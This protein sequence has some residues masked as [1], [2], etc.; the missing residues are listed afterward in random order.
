[1]SSINGVIPVRALSGVM[2]GKN[3]KA[4]LGMEIGTNLNG[5]AVYTNAWPFQNIAK[6]SEAWREHSGT[7]SYTINFNEDITSL[8]GDRVLS[9]YVAVDV[10]DSNL[11]MAGTWTV[12]WDGTA[13]VSVGNGAPP[14]FTGW[15]SGGSGTWS[16]TQ[17]LGIIVF[18]RNGTLSNLRV[19]PPGYDANNIFR[20]EWLEFQRSC[21]WRSIRTMD[22]SNINGSMVRNWADRTQVAANSYGNNKQYNTGLHSYDGAWA[23]TVPYEHQIALAN[24]LNCDLHVNIPT[25]ATDDFCQQL[26]ALIFANLNPNLKV[27]VEYSNETWNWIFYKATLWTNYLQATKR[28]ATGTTGDNT[29]TT[30]SHGLSENQQIVLVQHEKADLD[31][32]GSEELIFGPQTVRAINVTT[33]TFDIVSDDG[34]NTPLNFGF[35]HNIVYWFPTSEHPAAFNQ[36]LIDENHGVRSVEVWDAFKLGFT[37]HSRVV[38]VLASQASDVFRSITRAGVNGSNGRFDRFDIAHYFDQNE[39]YQDGDTPAEMSA[40]ALTDIAESLS[41]IDDHVTN[42]LTPIGCYEAGP[43]DIPAT[44]VGGTLQD[45]ID[46]VV[47]YNTSEF[48]YNNMYTYLQGTADRGVITYKHFVGDAN[49]AG[50]FGDWAIQTS[51]YSAEQPKLRVFREI[52]GFLEDTTA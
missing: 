7:G 51:L 47:A 42:N 38:E 43:H 22:W 20:P 8:S 1:M 19:Y 44:M 31:V 2:N 23:N 24:I 40:N 28:E 30:L 26:G 5:L 27:E 50:G 36:V 14:G 12:M 17:G 34:N 39:L 18:A 25:R 29:A 15:L 9:K 33:D 16:H 41:W 3:P 10:Q 21:H 46:A 49:P 6:I 4:R 37:D 52:A 11:P 45:R 35:G 32:T 48:M 13:E